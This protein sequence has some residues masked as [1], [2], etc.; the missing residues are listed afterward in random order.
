[1]PQ[2]DKG[3]QVCDACQGVSKTFNKR[4]RA[5]ERANVPDKRRTGGAAAFMHPSPS[6]MRYY[7]TIYAI[8]TESEHSSC[9]VSHP[10]FVPLHTY[11]R[12]GGEPESKHIILNSPWDELFTSLYSL[13]WIRR[14]LFTESHR[15]KNKHSTAHMHSSEVLGRRNLQAQISQ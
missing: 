6:I 7:V 3:D 8:R 13:G 15:C 11:T 12:G 2:R 14:F 9:S 5:S 4:Q 10:R 1:M